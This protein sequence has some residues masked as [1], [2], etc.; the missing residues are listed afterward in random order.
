MARIL[1]LYASL[2][3]QTA[4]V[5]G[6][7]A[8]TLRQA[9]HVV[10]TR[11]ARRDRAIPEARECDALIVGASVHYGRHPGWLRAAL[12]RQRDA[13]ATKPAAFF[14]VSLSANAQYAADFLRQVGWQ[15]AR[16]ASFAGALRYSR[17]GWFKRHLIRAFA[18]M[19]GHDTDASRDYEY[20]EW[21]SVAHFAEAFAQRL[22][23]KA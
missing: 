4:R 16:V 17:Y 22:A 9:G 7:I 8:E 11:E 6:R 12:R 1:V 10:E 13:L 3:G 2:E 21:G 14:S 15:P 5:A 18:R 23:T 19:G 20:T